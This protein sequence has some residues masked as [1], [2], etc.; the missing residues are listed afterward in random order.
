MLIEATQ[1]PL[2]VRFPDQ[3][4]LLEPGKPVDLPMDRARRL[5]AK[6]GAKVRVVDPM[7]PEGA[8]WTCGSRSFWI[9]SSDR[10]IC[11]MCHPPAVPEFVVD[12]LEVAGDDAGREVWR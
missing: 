1:R 4:I 6:A 5:L 2:T 3:E 12:W 8:C 10:I 9:S 7:R 11:A